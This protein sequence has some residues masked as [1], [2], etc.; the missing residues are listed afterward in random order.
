[1]ARPR[2][3]GHRG[4]GWSAAG[5]HTFPP[6]PTPCWAKCGAGPAKLGSRAAGESWD[7]NRGRVAS[8]TGCRG[9]KRG[10][11]LKLEAGALGSGLSAEIQRVGF[12]KQG[13]RGDYKIIIYNN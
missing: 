2:D 7:R 9:Q 11:D 10:L 4:E 3:P 8:D 12:L 5:A 6:A 13:R 1:M